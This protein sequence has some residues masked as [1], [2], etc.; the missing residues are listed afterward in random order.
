VSDW[1]DGARFGMFVHWDHIAQAGTEISWPLV[2]GAGG[3]HAAQGSLGV[4]DYHAT[5]ATFAPAKH[6]ARDWLARAKRAGMRY[7]VLTA[8]HHDGFAMWPTRTGQL[9]IA[10]SKY[11]GDLVR[12]FVDAA[13]ENGLRV[14][15][16]YSLCDWH[17]PDY[18]AFRDEHRPY[19]FGRTPRP[20]PEQWARFMEF[21][22]AQMRELMTD[23]GKIDLVWFDGGW[24]RSPEEWR[25]E[26]FIALIRGLQPGIVINDRLPGQGDYDTPEQ[27][28]PPLPPAR[29]WE[30]CLTMNE[31]WAWNPA[32]ARYKTPRA[33]VH[34][35]CEVASRGGNLLLN[36]SPMADGALP[37]EQIERL[38]ALAGWMARYGD[39]IHD[40]RPGLEPWQFYGPTTR[41]SERV[42]LHLLM[43]PY[44]TVSVRGVPVRRVRAVRELASG[45]ALE[46][47]GRTTILDQM[48]SPDPLGELTIFVP[49][50][51][52][53][54]L[55]TVI[56]L[57]IAS[58]A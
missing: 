43:R 5:A 36:V 47:R 26:E 18:P 31:T 33:L 15:I 38:D 19:R 58:R 54:P 28:I 16:Y 8:K 53:D 21:Q 32:D 45:R 22:F 46:H 37:A 10:H 24:E 30:T 57:E 11:E 44:E 40:S 20:T 48:T 1:F 23:Y 3:V 17:H 35:L 50:D 51:V 49:E 4:E 6:A 25:A 52:L 7:A 55:A 9:S 39:A 42:F 34:A 29:R 13:R 12:E 56:E 2:G 27:F 14:G 41:K